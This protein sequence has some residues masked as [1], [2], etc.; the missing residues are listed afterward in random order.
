MIKIYLYT[1]SSIDKC[2][3]L[4]ANIYEHINN[5]NETQKS[6]STSN[7]Q[8]L[9][10]K[11][12]E[13]GFDINNIYFSKYHKPLIEGMHL[14][15][16]H[17]KAYYGFALSLTQDIGIDIENTKRFENH[18]FAKKILNDSEYE[19]YLV[20]ESKAHYLTSKW[21]EKEALGKMQGTGLN[22]D[23]LKLTARYKKEITLNDEILVVVSDSNIEN[24]ELYIDDKKCEI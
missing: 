4:P 12:N 23:V 2:F 18:K 17:D 21:C 6:I 13:L 24:I 7:Y 16:T 1:S 14:S 9:S 22:N 3:N 20:S 10:I 8:K 19:K 15:L 11:L 5:Y